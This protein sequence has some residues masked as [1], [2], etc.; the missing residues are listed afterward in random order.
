MK[1]KIGFEVFLGIFLVFSVDAG[2]NTDCTTANGLVR[3]HETSYSG[4]PPP[5]PGFE[6]GRT[7][8][9]FSGA[10]VDRVVRCTPGGELPPERIGTCPSDPEIHDADLRIDFVP[11]TDRTL[12]ESP[13]DEPWHRVRK[14]VVEIEAARPSGSP[15]PNGIPSV[16]DFAL[17]EMNQIFAP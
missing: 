5:P 13:A 7:E 16:R 8:W 14:Y 9:I 10:V 6:V 2:A 4:G 17:C 1:A 12:Y 11:G 3:F 15:L